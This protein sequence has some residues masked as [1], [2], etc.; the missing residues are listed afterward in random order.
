M[1]GSADLL[2]LLQQ[3]DCLSVVGGAG[4]DLFFQ[5]VPE[6]FV[7]CLLHSVFQAKKEEREAG[8]LS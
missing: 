4:R 1:P 5:A 3:L 7:Q 8:G 2:Y 6:S